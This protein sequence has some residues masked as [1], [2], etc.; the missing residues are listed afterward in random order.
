M[1]CVMRR[2]EREIIEK[3]EIVEI[4]KK[5]DVCRVA[6]FDEEYP[7]IVPMNFGIGYD[8]ESIVLYFHG[9]HSGKKL[10]L[11]GQ[12]NNASFEMDCS[13]KLMIGDTACTCTMEYESVVG[14]GKIEIVGDDEK[15]N[16]LTHLM[17]N[18]VKQT[19]FHFDQGEMNAVTA[20]KL[21]VKNIWGKKLK[22]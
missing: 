14:N 19:S 20:F 18:Y 1:R 9:A 2:K 11:I 8:G 16:A 12:N 21:I 4:M 6:L 7:Y 10:T 17:R 3:D 15:H 13:H 5:C 22:R